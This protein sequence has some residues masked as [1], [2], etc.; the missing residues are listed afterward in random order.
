MK[1]N[2]AAFLPEFFLLLTVITAILAELFRSRAT[3]KTFYTIAKTGM[4]AAFLASVVFYNQTP[5]PGYYENNAHITLFKGVVYVLS[6][7][8][9]YLSLKWFLGLDR[10]SFAFY[11]LV[12]LSVLFLTAALSA[13]NLAVMFAF[14]TAA[15][16]LNIFFMYLDEESFT[17]ARR[18]VGTVL[19]V[20]V[21]VIFGLAEIYMQTGSLNFDK[22][23]AM[24]VSSPLNGRA[25]AAGAALL[26]VVFLML[27][28]A[29]FHL[30]QYETAEKGILPAVCFIN[31]VPVFIYF[32]VLVKLAGSLLA[33]VYM[34]MYPAVLGFA[35]LSVA[36]GALSA[37]GESNLRR[38]FVCIRVFVVGVVLAALGKYSLNNVFGS[39]VYLLVSLLALI[40]IHTV[41][42]GLKSKGVYLKQLQNISGVAESKPYLAAAMLF[43][44]VSLLGM[45]PLLGFLGI[46]SV[47]NVL[48]STGAYAVIAA[49]LFGFLVMAAAYLRV[50]RVMYFD[51]RSVLFDR[52]DRGIYL[53]LAINI[54]LV[55]ILLINPRFL[56]TDI[57]KLLF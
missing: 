49:V 30:W 44:M 43:F 56:L 17:A 27:G 1:Y 51:G 12:L 15:F 3:S 26:A 16:A 19:A 50:I 31:T 41:F 32:A 28:A 54:I 39:F 2:I 53:M 21:L 14:L 38:L 52:T 10:P 4:I 24:Y 45:P 47:T 29:P 11:L 9:M 46:L 34:T 37:N 6:G 8:C 22:V 5:L 33:P 7:S 25:Y 13:V 35:L 42:Y 20:I 23:A 48:V 18:L 57:E 40:G 36:V 55:L